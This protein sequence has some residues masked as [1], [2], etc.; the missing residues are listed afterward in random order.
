MSHADAGARA[1]IGRI[2]GVFGV[3]GELKVKGADSAELRPGLT[4][5]VTPADGAERALRVRSARSHGGMLLVAFDGIED[6]ET[7]SVISGCVLFAALEDLPSLPDGTYRDEQLVG[8]HVVDAR[9]GPLGDVRRVLHYPHADMLEVGE[10][11]TLVPM[12]AAFSV[13]V[14]LATQRITTRLPDG[15]EDL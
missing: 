12:L 11:A 6:P 3:R 13:A 15:F 7:A 4:V 8:M 10:R 14:D 1:A 2:G 9:L 5:F